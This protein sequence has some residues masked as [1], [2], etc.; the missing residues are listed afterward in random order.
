MSSTEGYGAAIDTLECAS[1]QFEDEG[2]LKMSVLLLQ[3]ARLA[4]LTKSDKFTIAAL[5]KHII[6]LLLSEASRNEGVIE[7]NF[8]LDELHKRLEHIETL[9]NKEELIKKQGVINE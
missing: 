5:S 8:S 9:I 4:A 6:G 2:D 1:K 7:L 3:I